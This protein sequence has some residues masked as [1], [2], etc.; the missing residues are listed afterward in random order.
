MS[1]IEGKT[2]PAVPDQLTPPLATPR[3]NAPSG[4]WVYEIKYQGHRLLARIVGGEVRLFHRSGE[5]WTAQLPHQATAVGTLGLNDT[6]LDGEIVALDEDGAPNLKVL[7]ETL[8]TGQTEGLVY[9]LFDLP[10]LSCQDLRD[11]PLEERRIQLKRIVSRSN[12]RLLRFSDAFASREPQVILEC[13]GLLHIDG[14]IGKRSGSP[15]Q[16]ELSPDWIKLDCAPE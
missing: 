6:W 3:D 11:Q 12:H 8:R 1:D 14:L 9:Y 5:D 15:Y 10:F 7:Q 4:D 16:S 2:V 13:A